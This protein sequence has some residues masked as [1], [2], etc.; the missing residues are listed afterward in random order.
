[1]KWNYFSELNYSFLI[2][3][4][5]IIARAIKRGSQSGAPLRNRQLTGLGL[6]GVT[7]GLE[8]SGS[9]HNTRAASRL[10]G[11][12]TIGSVTGSYT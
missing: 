12:R 4:Q 6:V 2:I 11:H 9:A 5:K 10:Q 7:V 1:M 8:H 3:F